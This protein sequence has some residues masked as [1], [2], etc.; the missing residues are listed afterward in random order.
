M[1]NI[2]YLFLI[3][4]L[5]VFIHPI[6]AHSSEN[7]EKE[8]DNILS[9][10]ESLFKAMKDNDHKAIW[11]YLTSKS[12]KMIVEDT[13]KSAIKSGVEYTREQ[14]NVD[15]SIGGL[16]AKSYWKGFLSTFN[17]DIVLEHST[18][19]MGLVEG[20]RSEVIITYK[21]SEKPAILKM[22]KEDGVWKVG[23]TETFWTRK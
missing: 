16:I 12:K 21:K 17:P 15:F 3:I 18:W 19:E 10:A 2:P 1:K 14:I 11:L 20:N 7:L 22:F 5:L 13:Y 23:F 9:S 4:C 6:H 8:I